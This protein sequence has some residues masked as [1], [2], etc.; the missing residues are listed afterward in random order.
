[1]SQSRIIK[2]VATT[3]Y[4]VP[5]LGSLK[6]GA[7]SSMDEARHVL[8]EVEL[9]DGSIGYAEAPPRPTIYG[10]TVYSIASIIEHELAPRILDTTI[11]NYLVEGYQRLRQV[12]NNHTARAAIDI[13]LYDAIAKSRGE[14]LAE[15]LTAEQAKVKVSYILGINTPDQM[16]AEAAR[17]Y[18]QGVR[19]FKV[20]VG[21]NWNTDLETLA[22]LRRELGDD[23]Q[24]YADANE[25]MSPK[26]AVERLR[27]LADMN[28]LYCEEPL[29]V[30]LLQD[31]QQLR[32][33][34]V[35][36]IIGDDS[37]FTPNDLERE[38]A[39][40]TFDVLNIK[41]ARTG[42]TESRKML[43]AATNSGKGVM[44]GS[45]ASTG[46]GTIRAALFAAKRGIEHPSE[47]SFFLKLK[48][49]IIDAPLQ[50]HDGYMHIEDIVNIKIDPDLLREATVTL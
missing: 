18:A 39:L 42:Y 47:L 44:V 19:V 11:S 21:R 31:R 10:E 38:L 23:A 49:D 25:T 43:G 50:L 1:M 3:V 33:K 29:R 40:D 12:K 24:F 48:E 27:Q 5:L 45:Q 16:L 26:N 41:T 30:N 36:P 6:W 28:L 15:Y 13:A 2:R 46:L 9:D 7:H 22:M 14:T 8:V 17:V 35:L 32:Q 37:T 20:K 34:N 4:R